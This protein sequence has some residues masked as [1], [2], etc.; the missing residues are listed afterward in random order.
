MN[1]KTRASLGVAVIILLSVLLALFRTNVLDISASNERHNNVNG[2]DVT[3]QADWGHSQYRC[4][5]GKNDWRDVVITDLSVPNTSVSIQGHAP[6]TEGH[7]CG[8][9]T[10]SATATLHFNPRSMQRM[11]VHTTRTTSCDANRPYANAGV[12]GFTP[13]HQESGGD[14]TAKVTGGD[15]VIT[16][17]GSAITIE[18][19]GQGIT[20]SDLTRNLT[21]TMST[22]GGNKA[23]ARMHG[24]DLQLQITSIDVT[25]KTLPPIVTPPIY[26]PPVTPPVVTTNTTAPPITEQPGPSPSW[27]ER[28]WL[29]IKAF[30]AGAFR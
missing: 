5:L 3:Y 16:N 9:Y 17:T 14:A 23:G 15:I 21:I 13:L 19:D 11:V 10:V 25:N 29:T 20:T 4:T 2:I 8:Q 27:L 22:D 1:H 7:N 28:L 6:N 12:T 30:L 18:T 26:N 24:C